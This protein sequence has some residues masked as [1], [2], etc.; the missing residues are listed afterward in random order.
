M[1]VV[2]IG[3]RVIVRT[4]VPTDLARLVAMDR[5]FTGRTR[6]A[7]FEGKLKRAL[8][9]T[10]VRISVGAEMDG[11]LGGA[12]MG[13]LAYGEFG[14]PEPVAILDTALVERALAGKGIGRAMLA[15]LL[16]NLSALRIETIRT[17]VGWNEREL[18]AFLERTGWTPVPRLVLELDVKKAE[19]AFDIEESEA[20]KI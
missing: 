15:Q 19:K 10:G 4:L 17:E 3:R 2:E 13:S 5:E 9:E 1:D 6:K 16:K 18:L 11:R 12:L 20:A 14:R 8:E 7:W